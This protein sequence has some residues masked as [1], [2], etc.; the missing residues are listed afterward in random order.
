MDRLT[1]QAIF[2]PTTKSTWALDV[3]VLFIQHI[4][5]VRGL[6]KTLI[7]D[8]DPIFTSNFSQFLL[9]I[10]ANRS[11]AFCPLT[12]GQTERLN[13]VLE[14]YLRMYCDY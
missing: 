10:R 1:M 12:D 5:R 6:P 2:I 9:G 3:A 11:S 14:K 4:M 13:S 7:S 8:R